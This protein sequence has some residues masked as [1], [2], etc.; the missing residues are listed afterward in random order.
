MIS[1]A[2]ME[3]CP[4]WFAFDNPSRLCKCHSLNEWVIC[5]QLSGEVELAK[6]FC[7]TFDNRTGNTDVG[8]CPYTILDTPHVE[9]TRNGYVELPNDTVFLNEFMCGSWNR[10]GYLCSK[11]KKGYGLTIANIFQ[12]CVE[13]RYP[14]P[15]GWLLYF[16]LQLIPLTVLFFVVSVFRISLARPPM[17]AFVVFCQMCTVILFTQA[18]NFYPPYVVDSIVL[19]RLHYIT[20]LGLGIWSMTLTRYLDCGITNFCVDP[21]VSVQQAFTLT[22][23]QSLFPLLLVFLTHAS[24]ILH[25]R[26]CRL[27]VWL[28]RPF[29]RYCVRFSHIWNSKLSLVDVFSTFLLLS[30]SRFV[31]QL[32]YMFSFQYTYGLDGG[33]NHTASL[34]YNPTISYFHPLYHL[35]YAL[36]LLFI[37]LMVVGP[38][39]VLLTFYQSTA[40]QKFLTSICLHKIPSVH[41][42]VDI[43]HGCYKNGTSGTYDLR[44]VSSF[45]L[46]L[47]V[48]ALFGFIG[49]NSTSLAS[50]S[51]I[52]IFILVFLLLLFFALFRPYKNQRMNISDSLLLAA[53]A[54]ICFLLIITSQ[55]TKLSTFNYMILIIVLVIV[56]FPQ[57][58]LYSY[59][60]Y[61][62]F[63]HIVKTDYFHGFVMQIQKVLKY[64]TKEQ[65][66]KDESMEF[67]LTES[68]LNRT[69]NLDSDEYLQV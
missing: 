36:L 29:H 69:D 13:C 34:L 28:W 33:I 41:I 58:I 21:D 26:N 68:F 35:P 8:K 38:P 67:D 9:R 32:Y 15:L 12:K 63:R 30:Y 44:F 42:F 46:M 7:M 24:I 66:V 6:G 62:I 17:N 51:L 37:F 1:A 16:M 43:F 48:V 56:V 49:C 25:T 10:E 22:Q 31:F 2:K 52:L 59:F 47:R 11:C 19:Q 57:A 60:L 45:Y 5:N 61:K 3:L 14:K 18:N 53:L 39:I 27:I 55:N 54:V 50:C 4:T 64:T 20:F 23:I 40:F 65:P